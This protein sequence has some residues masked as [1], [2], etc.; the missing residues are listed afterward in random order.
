MD[1]AQRGDDL[2]VRDL[3][4]QLLELVGHDQHH[5]LDVVV[6][7]GRLVVLVDA[8]LADL[9]REQAGEDRDRADAAGH[10]EHAPASGRAKLSGE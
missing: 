4:P 5:A 2:G 6:E 3:G 7:L 8:R 10:H 1:L 9:V